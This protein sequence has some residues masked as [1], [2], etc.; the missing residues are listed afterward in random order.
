MDVEEETAGQIQS[1][2]SALRK[3]INSE[4]FDKVVE[5]S[6]KSKFVSRAPG[7]NLFRS[8]NAVCW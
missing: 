7:R 3:H 2:F 8:N 5:T 1:L 4:E 6:D